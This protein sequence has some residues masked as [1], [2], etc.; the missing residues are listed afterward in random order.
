MQG[1]YQKTETHNKDITLK[2]MAFNLKGLFQGK[3]KEVLDSAFK[4]L[5]GLI[6]N[7][8]EL[9]TIKLQAEQELNRHAEAMEASA[10]K[11]LDLQL[12]DISNARNTNV[13]IQESDK[14]SWMAKNIAY[15][16]DI[17]MALIWGI[18]TIYVAALWA[19]VISSADVDFTGILSLYST[20]T[21]VFM[22]TVN[23]H[24]G[25]SQG[26]QDK[27]KLLDRINK[28]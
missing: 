4:G 7:K 25:T 21:A 24:R 1:F 14:A 13:S 10:N 15:L 3:A 27:Q 11:E 17:W 20:V 9:A 5:D 26:S 23:F 8:E 16:I 19:K 2:N 22:I 18:F 6:T 12:A 28:R